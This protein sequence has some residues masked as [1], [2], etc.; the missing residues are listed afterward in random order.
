MNQ[1][2]YL[3][4][5]ITALVFLLAIVFFILSD[6]FRTRR[7][8]MQ[9]EWL[10]QKAAEEFTE[11]R[12]SRKPSADEMQILREVVLHNKVLPRHP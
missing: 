6:V 1:Y 7:Q 2:G 5:T 4:I 9:A 3:V 10:L 12:T 8:R 11:A